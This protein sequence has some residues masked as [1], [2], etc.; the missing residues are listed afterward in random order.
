MK[1]RH[2]IIF[3]IFALL[4]V[5]AFAIRQFTTWKELQDSSDF[6][7]WA[8]A[9]KIEETGECKYR[10]TFTLK[11]VYK[12]TPPEVL[13]FDWEDSPRHTLEQHRFSALDLSSQYILFGK[14]EGSNYSLFEERY[15]QKRKGF[16]GMQDFLYDHVSIFYIRSLPPELEEKIVEKSNGNPQKPARFLKWDDIKGWLEQEYPENKETT[17]KS[18]KRECLAPSPHTTKHAAPHLAVRKTP[19]PD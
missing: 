4:C 7:V 15:M 17:A 2:S 11:R 13:S 18:G 14:D 12:G 10:I 9:T 5:Q 6:I 19:P 16:M 8:K 3:L 1:Q